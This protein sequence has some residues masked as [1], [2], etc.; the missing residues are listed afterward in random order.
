M[1]V[2]GAAGRGTDWRA[3]RLYGL[4]ALVTLIGA[5]FLVRIYDWTPHSD[6]ATGDNLGLSRYNYSAGGFGDLVPGQDGHWVTWHHRPYH[7]QTNSVGLR[8]TEEASGAA[9]RILAVGDS[10]TF[11]PFLAN[12][13]TWPAWTENYLRQHDRSATQTQVFNAGIIGYTIVDELNYLKDKALVFKPQL[14]VLAVFENDLR[15]LLKEHG[16]IKK[17]AAKA[18]AVSGFSNALRTI[19]RN[20]ALVTLANE[21]KTR[22]KLASAGVD[23]RLGGVRGATGWSPASPQD[24]ELTTRY[25]A[26][27]NQTATLLKSQEIDLAVL[28]IPAAN[29]IDDDSAS[30]MEPVIRAAT[31]ATRSPYL[32]LTP[33]FR[34]QSDALSRLYLL[35]RGPKGELIGDGH[36]SREGNAVIGRALADWLVENNLPR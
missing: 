24:A 20:L 7:V 16:G 15:D 34:A 6:F 19:G 21:I 2:I 31:A 9:V 36:L 32:N 17:R 12:E 22:I 18:A 25:A 27:F 28:F 1:A 11:G 3:W 4:I 13:D 8:N 30:I 14:V 35:Q 29:S 5:E 23:V 26:L 33:V 10:Q